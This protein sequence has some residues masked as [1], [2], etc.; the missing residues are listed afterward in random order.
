LFDIEGTTLLYLLKNSDPNLIRIIIT[1]YPSI[2]NAVQ[3]INSDTDRKIV[4]PF[5]PQKLLDQTKKRLERR[6]K[7]K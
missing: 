3:S 5:K 2:E 4:K 6:Q 1:A 7:E